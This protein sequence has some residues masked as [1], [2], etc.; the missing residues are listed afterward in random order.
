M[1]RRGL[2]SSFAALALVPGLARASAYPDRQS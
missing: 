2:L 1:L